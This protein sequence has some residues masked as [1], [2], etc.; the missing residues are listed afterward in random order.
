MK[1]F[2]SMM[3]EWC[4]WLH[5]YYSSVHY[6][7]TPAWTDL[8]G[9]ANIWQHITSSQ[10]SSS[11]PSFV[12]GGIFWLKIAS[13][14]IRSAH[15]PTEVLTGVNVSSDY[16]WNTSVHIKH[17]I[18]HLCCDYSWSVRLIKSFIVLSFFLGDLGSSVSSEPYK[19]TNLALFLLTERF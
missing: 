16:Q 13:S 9:L 18:W 1:K 17:G 7:I 19:V 12:G 10:Q 11:R 15:V 2:N 5:H 3:L 8:I 14:Q 4:V 6:C